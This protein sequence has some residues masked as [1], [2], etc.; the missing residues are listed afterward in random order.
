MQGKRITRD[1][2]R[3]GAPFT[4]WQFMVDQGRGKYCSRACVN[5][6]DKR[7]CP[8]CGGPKGFD[9]K[10]C[11]RCLLARNAD[12]DGRFD[13][14]V[15]TS[16]PI[17]RHR[18]ELGACAVWTGGT[19]G[20]GYG[21]FAIREFDL[22]PA[23][24]YAWQRVNGP[25][26]DKLL[27][28]HKCDN[29]PCVRVSHLFLGTAKD[30][31]DDMWAKGRGSYQGGPHGEAA[32]LAKLTAEIVRDIRRR[33]ASGGISSIA[34]AAEYGVTSGAILAVV[35]RRTWKHVA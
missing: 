14:K 13:E 17:P 25:I 20:F 4:T 30:N 18:P 1:C 21:V 32:G 26:P 27:V 34:L 6:P 8:L 31:T 3:C 22:I 16:G 12:V 10:R 2:L 7:V 15:N 5:R 29:P 11:M 23:H 24:R 19:T 9:A 35:H 33:Y 28:L